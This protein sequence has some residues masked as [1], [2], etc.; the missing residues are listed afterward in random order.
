MTYCRHRFV[1]RARGTGRARWPHLGRSDWGHDRS[2]SGRSDP[3]EGEL[4][5]VNSVRAAYLVQD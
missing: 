5:L 3:M 2:A 4:G 1:E